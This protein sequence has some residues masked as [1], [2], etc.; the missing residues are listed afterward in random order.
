[1]NEYL[2][3]APLNATLA[4]TRAGYAATGQKA[5]NAASRLLKQPAIQA[6]IAQVRAR[7][8]QKFEI[9]RER[10]MA[11]YAK[12]AFNDP[13][14]YFDE[15]GDL[16]HP[17]MLDDASAAAL[18]QFEVEEEYEDAPADEE[19]EGQ[20][21]GGALKRR[22][23]RRIACGRTAKIKWADKRGALDSIVRMMG[24]G[25]GENPLGTPENPLTMIVKDLQGRSSALTPV[26][27]LDDDED[28]DS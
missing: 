27:S 8:A 14:A 9:T 4:Y 11:E 7:D 19:L 17:S 12:L 6:A 24:W 16:K 5:S 3:T 10:V 15:N 26:A 22:S 2:A 25:N 13:R 28:D 21:H 20:P 18:V 1:M 23:A